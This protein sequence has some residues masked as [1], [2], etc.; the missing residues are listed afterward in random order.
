VAHLSWHI[1][2]NYS[3]I[4]HSDYVPRQV[5]TFWNH[6]ENVDLFGVRFARVANYFDSLIFLQFDSP[7][8]DVVR[9]LQRPFE[10]NETQ[11]VG[12]GLH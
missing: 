10:Y 3:L 4:L 8:F 11:F 9:E 12:E 7:D 1:V 6:V 2:H 5:A